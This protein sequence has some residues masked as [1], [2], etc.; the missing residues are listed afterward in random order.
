MLKGNQGQDSVNKNERAGSLSLRWGEWLL[1]RIYQLGMNVLFPPVLL[2]L[3]P[4]LLIKRKRRTTL[5]PRLGFQPSPEP[6]PSTGGAARGS[7]K[8]LWVHALSV[9]EVF[10][11]VPLI[12]ELHARIKPARL[13]LSVST[14]SGHE[15][16]KNKLEGS[17][18]G[19]F[20]FPLDLLFAVRRCFANLKPVSYTHLTLPTTPYV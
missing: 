10:S 5:L 1:L 11:A 20:Y 2:A 6:S 12:R 8:A 3:S 7:E 17:L 4:I 13:Y 18:D 19:L 14:L 9:G 15:A 16:A